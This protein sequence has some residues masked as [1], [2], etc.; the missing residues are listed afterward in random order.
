MSSFFEIVKEYETKCEKEDIPTETVMTEN[1]QEK[2]PFNKE[3]IPPAGDGGPYRPPSGGKRPDMSSERE[4][5]PPAGTRQPG[6]DKNG[7]VPG[8]AVPTSRPTAAPIPDDIIP[9]KG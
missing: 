2:G 3:Q 9:D 1:P 6:R 7:Q 4:S 5:Q 8:T